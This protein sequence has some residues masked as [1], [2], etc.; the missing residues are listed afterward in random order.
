MCRTGAHGY[1]LKHVRCPVGLFQMSSCGWMVCKPL[2]FNWGSAVSNRL[3]HAAGFG[4]SVQMEKRA[5][6][7]HAEPAQRG[8]SFRRGVTTSYWDTA[9]R[10]SCRRYF[11]PGDTNVGSRPVCGHA[12]R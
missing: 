11:A 5:S 2:F 8:S 10:R 6:I 12:R 4:D 9:S 3:I 7:R 1:R